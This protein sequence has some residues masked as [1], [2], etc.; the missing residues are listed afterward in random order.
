MTLRDQYLDTILALMRTA[1]Q[2]S[3]Q[4]VTTGLDHHLAA[5]EQIKVEIVRIKI[6]IKRSELE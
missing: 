2:L 3:Y 5:Y 6:M 1:D 4:Y